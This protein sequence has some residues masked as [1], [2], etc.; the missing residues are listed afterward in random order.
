MWLRRCGRFELAKLGRDVVHIQY[1]WRQGLISVATKY[2]MLWR[3][4]QIII[5]SM[6]IWT[7][8]VP[9][10]GMLRF[11]ITMGHV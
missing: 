4:M 9:Q 6:L 3:L 8:L 5:L 7:M 11:V 2:I 10:V 1:I